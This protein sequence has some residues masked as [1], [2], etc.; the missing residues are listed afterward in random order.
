MLY[1]S[2]R[3]EQI[4]NYTKG[5]SVPTLVVETEVPLR[6]TCGFPAYANF[7][8]SS[9]FARSIIHKSKKRLFVLKYDI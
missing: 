5:T 3:N 9:F 6:K 2:E 4:S 1:Q 8:N 7:W